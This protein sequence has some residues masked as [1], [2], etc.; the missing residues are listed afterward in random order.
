MRLPA[1]PAHAR[2]GLLALA[3]AATGASPGGLP[4]IVFVSRNPVPGDPSAIPGLGPHHRAVVTGGRLLVR[5]RD[6]R[7]RE[8]LPPG[9][10][11]DVSDPSVSPDARRIAFAGVAHPDSAWRIWV[12]NLDGTDLRQLT[13]Y[14]GFDGGPPRILRRGLPALTFPRY[15]D[16]DPCWTSGSSI[17]FASTRFPQRAQYADLPVTNLFSTCVDDE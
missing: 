12:V 1:V 10:F 5:E 11:Y 13:F 9:A 8:L 15:D 6:G 3:L 14:Y 2:V 16:L 17:V 7:L 4:A